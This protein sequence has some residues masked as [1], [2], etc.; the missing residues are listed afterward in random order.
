[1]DTNNKQPNERHQEPQE[2]NVI[3]TASA[4]TSK[5]NQNSGSFAYVITAVAIGALLVLSLGSAGCVAAIVGAAAQEA[6][7]GGHGSTY[8]PHSNPNSNLNLDDMYNMDFEEFMRQYENE[9]NGYGSTN[10]SSSSSNKRESGTAPVEDVLDYRIAPYGDTID[11]VLGAN[12]YAGAPTE[13]RD[14][15][16]K[17][18]STD[19][20]YADKLQALLHATAKDKS[21]REA[22]LKEASDLCDEANKAIAALEVPSI[23]GSNG[24]SVKD[25]LGSAKSEAAHRWEL[26]KAE[27]AIIASGDEI[28]TKKLWRADEDVV[29]ST[30]E[31]ASLLEDAMEQSAKK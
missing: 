24:A 7:T 20:D 1:M 18:V 12:A 15:V 21:S 8:A 25:M 13:V 9:L 11:D 30:E 22:K 14:F 19:E 29:D 2:P 23:G 5:D 16:R 17:I 10:G 3:E 6:S 4:T 31:A 28:E 26:M 27:V